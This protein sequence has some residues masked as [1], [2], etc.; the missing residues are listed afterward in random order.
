[1]VNG[2]RQEE[3]EVAI[4]RKKS[5]PAKKVVLLIVWL[6]LLGGLIFWIKI[7]GGSGG[8]GEALTPPK[9]TPAPV[10][11]TAMLEAKWPQIIAHAAA[12]ARGAADAPYTIAEFGDFQCPQCGK[13]YPVLETLLKKSPSQVNMIFLHRPFPTLHQWALPAG[14]ASEIAAASGKFWPMYDLLYTHQDNLET[15]YYGDYAVKA[16]LNEAKFKAAFNAGQGQSE[17]KADSA[18]ADSLGVQ[19]T[20]TILLRDNTAKTV[21]VYVGTI[22]TKNADSSPQY[23]GVQSLASQPPW[24]K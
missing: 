2:T 24:A 12:P 6:A 22:G 1:M 21:T 14:Q 10:L 8:P 15:G 3:T 4:A 18:F 11:N 23:P 17:I 9:P 13:V 16:G 20:P 5:G 7:M 19:E